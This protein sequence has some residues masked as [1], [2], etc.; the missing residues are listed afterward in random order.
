MQQNQQDFNL[1][2]VPS[3]HKSHSNSLISHSKTSLIEKQSSKILGSYEGLDKNYTPQIISNKAQSNLDLDLVVQLS[4]HSQ[5]GTRMSPGDGHS[6]K[7][8]SH[9]DDYQMRLSQ[10]F[11]T[12]DNYQKRIQDSK[13]AQVQQLYQNQQLNQSLNTQSQSH[14]SPFKKA[15]SNSQVRNSFSASST[16]KHLSNA[17]TTNYHQYQQQ[18]QNNE[19]GLSNFSQKHYDSIIS[20]GIKNTNLQSNSAT[21]NNTNGNNI[22]ANSSNATNT[23]QQRNSHARSF[24]TR[25]DKSVE[26]TKKSTNAYSS[27]KKTED[28][29][30]SP[31]KRQSIN[32]KSKNPFG[33]SPVQQSSDQKL[34]DH[35]A[36]DQQNS[37]Q[38]NQEQQYLT[39]QQINHL[40]VQQTSAQQKSPG[41]SSSIKRTKYLKKIESH[42]HSKPYQKNQSSNRLGSKQN[43]VSNNLNQTLTGSQR[44]SGLN[45]QSCFIEEGDSLMQDISFFNQINQNLSS[46]NAGSKSTKYLGAGSFI[47]NATSNGRVQRLF[48]KQVQ[49]EGIQKSPQSKKSIEINPAFKSLSKSV[50]EK[51]LSMSNNLKQKASLKDLMNSTIQTQDNILNQTQNSNMLLSQT[52]QSNQINSG[53]KGQLSLNNTQTQSQ[54]NIHQGQKNLASQ[55]Y[56]MHQM[57]LQ[58]QHTPLHFNSTKHL[59]QNTESMIQQQTPSSS[60]N[61]SDCFNILEPDNFKECIQRSESMGVPIKSYNSKFYNNQPQQNNQLNKQLRYDEHTDQYY[62]GLDDQQNLQTQQQLDTT[63]QRLITEIR[64]Q[65]NST[66]DYKKTLNRNETGD[67]NLVEFD[68]QLS[69]L[70]Q[71]SCRHLYPMPTDLPSQRRSNSAGIFEQSLLVSYRQQSS[72]FDDQSFIRE[73]GGISQFDEIT[74]QR[75]IDLNSILKFLIEE[76]EKLS[77]FCN[78]VQQGQLIEMQQ[79]LPPKFQYQYLDLIQSVDCK[80]ERPKFFAQQLQVTIILTN[81]LIEIFSPSLMQ[82]F[83]LKLRTVY[84]NAHQNFLLFIDQILNCCNINPKDNLN[85]IL[86]RKLIV[87]KLKNKLKSKRI[88]LL[89]QNNEVNLLNLK[90]ICKHMS[91][92]GSMTQV[93]GS[94]DVQ[95]NAFHLEFKGLGNE[96]LEIL[97]AYDR[98]NIPSIY[99]KIQIKDEIVKSKKNQQTIGSPSRRPK[100]IYKNHS[101]K[102]SPRNGLGN[103]SP[104][105]SNKSNRS[106]R[107]S[108]TSN[109]SKGIVSQ[110]RV[111]PSFQQLRKDPGIQK[112]SPISGGKT[113]TKKLDSSNVDQ[114]LP[115]NLSKEQLSTIDN[116]IKSQTEYAPGEN[117]Q[118]SSESNQGMFFLPESMA[119]ILSNSIQC[120]NGITNINNNINIYNSQDIDLKK[121]KEEARNAKAI[122]KINTKTGK[123]DIESQD[124]NR[125]PHIGSGVPFVKRTSYNQA[126]Q[127]P[128]KA[129]L[130]QAVSPKKSQTKLNKSTLS[131]LDT[132]IKGVN[133]TRQALSRQNISRD[134]SKN[135]ILTNQLSVFGDEDLERL[136]FNQVD[137]SRENSGLS[138]VTHS[139]RNVITSNQTGNKKI[140]NRPMSRQ[141]VNDKQKAIFDK[142]K[143]TQQE[144]SP[145]TTTSYLRPK[146]RQNI[147]SSTSAHKAQVMNKKSQLGNDTSDLQ[148][149]SLHSTPMKSQNPDYITNTSSSMGT[150]KSYKPILSGSK[151]TTLQEQTLSSK[152]IT[153]PG[154]QNVKDS[155]L[156]PKKNISIV[157]PQPKRTQGIVQKAPGKS[158]IAKAVSQQKQQHDSMINRPKEQISCFQ[159]NQIGLEVDSSN[160]GER[161]RFYSESNLHFEKHIPTPS[162]QP[163]SAQNKNMQV[164]QL[165]QRP[166]DKYDEIFDQ[167]D[168]RL[169]SLLDKMNQDIKKHQD[170]N[171]V[172]SKLD[173]DIVLD[174]I[175]LQQKQ[176]SD[177]SGYDQHQNTNVT[178]VLPKRQ[179]HTRT[180][181]I[182]QTPKETE[183]KSK[184]DV[185]LQDDIQS[186]AKILQFG[187]FI[188]QHMDSLDL[189]REMEKLKQ[190]DEEQKRLKRISLKINTRAI[191]QSNLNSMNQSVNGSYTNNTITDSPGKKILLGEFDETNQDDEALYLN[192]GDDL[193]LSAESHKHKIAQRQQIAVEVLDFEDYITQKTGMEDPFPDYVDPDEEGTPGPSAKNQE[194][195]QQQ[196]KQLTDEQEARRL[197]DEENARLRQQVK[198]PYLT[199][200][201]K[202]EYNRTY[203][204]VLDLDETLIHFECDEEEQ[205]ED[206]QGYYLIRPGAIKFLNE[207]SK[208]YELVIFTA[209]MP[210]VSIVFTLY[211]S[212]N[213]MLIGFLTTQ[214]DTKQSSTDFTDNTPLLTKIMPCNLHFTCFQ[215]L[216]LTFTS[217][218]KDLRNLGRALERTIIIDNLAENFIHT[219][220][221]NGIWVESWY[222]DMDDTVMELLIPFLKDIVMSR[223]PDVRKILT[224]SNKE[225]ILYR[226]LE[227]NK[228]IPPVQELLERTQNESPT[229]RKDKSRQD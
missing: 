27:N 226:Y 41:N 227:E 43:Q 198:I 20:S 193:L 23:V 173:M 58:S 169:N 92:Y 201:E 2:E 136:N 127:L 161:E 56:T 139:T 93:S 10:Q 222:D 22:Y 155:L 103:Y 143:S 17:K 174:K 121:L 34:K 212:I 215:P 90:K 182:S 175:N 45:Q 128:V 163:Y 149:Q 19:D 138:Q 52:L 205:D 77:N 180:A 104:A 141:V 59:P 21:K 132:S 153:K 171:Q 40:S 66:H 188:E 54:L 81:V 46:I 70:Q 91:T 69:Y 51:Q 64:L 94:G 39:T 25:L 63:S 164:N 223:V 99:E 152:K 29:S 118:K 218:S 65:T 37:Q 79:Q 190:L 154:T 207:L 42:I 151:K 85:Y 185:D 191:D 162:Q 8:K 82:K 124:D 76:E 12:P 14:S 196:Q 123:I 150:E 97:R 159:L 229:L 168:D 114:L 184:L 111:K 47:Q 16:N 11:G 189:K 137:L 210:D 72:R 108:I 125:K 116:R 86:L 158:F 89:R 186:G 15:V 122:G 220:P 74:L 13:I 211:K 1:S 166:K 214:T 129:G 156:I 113:S 35:L 178:Q 146:S 87:K 217:F 102:A 95:M 109:S 32:S 115:Q 31:S 50:S 3:P 9:Q 140:V 96:M 98:M 216:I 44:V 112:K 228:E 120:N 61:P 172:Q 24:S 60:S 73:D 100:S 130:N 206:E 134:N 197:N 179:D 33:R 117:T 209:A 26:N 75:N 53:L 213:S 4:P 157:S 148:L 203:T 224:K 160:E 36:L 195:Q 6:I 177:R 142:Q 135:E 57:R 183:R 84:T 194:S 147:G 225:N 167:N 133:K 38:Y 131:G 202:N 101:P 83:S 219:T 78:M 28:T 105:Q 144:R 107:N 106:G 221:D 49:N 71:E 48:K 192:M 5:E 55:N 145:H 30:H 165:T 80:K 176:D 88:T 199:P 67:E 62:E 126:K 170:Q 68:D 7:N 119:F 204:L 208:Y 200:L 181:S 187:N 110:Q 18:L